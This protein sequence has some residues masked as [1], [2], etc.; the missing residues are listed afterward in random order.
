MNKQLNLNKQ[1]LCAII[2]GETLDISNVSVS[3]A[4][5]FLLRNLLRFVGIA[6]HFG[7][8]ILTAVQDFASC[9]I[10]SPRPNYQL[11]SLSPSL[12]WLCSHC[13]RPVSWRFRY[14][15]IS[16]CQIFTQTRTH[17]HTHA[18]FKIISKYSS[19]NI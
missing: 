17:T 4:I 6:L 10:P 2:N 16:Q 19:I 12:C 1:F 15:V 14:G 13:A 11:L 8:C 9:S 7:V 5:N 18:H 3:F